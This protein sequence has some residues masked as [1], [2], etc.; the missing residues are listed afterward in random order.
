M[1]NAHFQPGVAEQKTGQEQMILVGA[2]S[3]MRVLYNFDTNGGITAT[4]SDG[5][6]GG[7][8][9]VSLT[10]P[11]AGF[12]AETVFDGATGSCSQM[13]HCI[14]D[15]NHVSILV[16]TPYTIEVFAHVKVPANFPASIVAQADPYIYI[17]NGPTLAGK[18]G[19]H[20]GTSCACSAHR[21]RSDLPQ[22]P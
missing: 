16:N 7:D 3:G 5:R 19:E 22:P 4:A 10:G 20:G 13:T 9:H 1:G 6:F 14:N 2:P 12:K 11:T 8:V 17:S 18:S 21:N 15:T